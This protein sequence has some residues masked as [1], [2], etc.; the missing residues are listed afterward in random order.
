MAQSLALQVEEPLEPLT[1]LVSVMTLYL[2]SVWVLT[3]TALLV[4]QRRSN[5]SLSVRYF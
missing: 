2:L 4:T 3:L 1:A 5:D